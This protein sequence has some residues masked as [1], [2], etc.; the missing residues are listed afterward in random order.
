MQILCPLT[1]SV[2]PVWYHP[3][4]QTP[5]HLPQMPKHTAIKAGPTAGV[6]THNQNDMT[7]NDIRDWRRN[8]TLAKQ[9][10][11]TKGKKN[12]QTKQVYN[13]EALLFTTTATAP[14]SPAKGSTIPLSC[15]Y[16]N[17]T[18]ILT[19]NLVNLSPLTRN[20]SMCPFQPPS[21]GGSQPN[22]RESSGFL[23]L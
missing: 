3:L 9:Y 5:L 8:L 14:N 20:S 4:P 18:C 23:F 6:N 16:L 22:P 21:G 19:Y 7:S 12:K 10:L 17:C 13:L 15:P 1:R 11:H 2:I